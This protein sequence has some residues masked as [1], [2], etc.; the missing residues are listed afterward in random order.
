M[1]KIF[2][3]AAAAFAFAGL[4]LLSACGNGEAAESFPSQSD[5]VFDMDYSDRLAD[6]ECEL[7]YSN[8]FCYADREEYSSDDEK[9]TVTVKNKNKGKGFWV[10]SIANVERYSDGEWVRLNYFPA[11]HEIPERWGFCAI[12]GRDDVCYSTVVSI[13]LDRLEDEWTAGDYRAVIYV[14]RETIYAPFKIGG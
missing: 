9:I 7:D 2:G 4:L 6:A 1:R 12:E 5:A 11:S 13:W 3:N 8:I 10:C 14:G